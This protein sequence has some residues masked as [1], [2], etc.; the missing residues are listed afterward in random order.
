VKKHALACIFIV[1][2]LVSL[3]TLILP[4][5]AA[6]NADS[7]FSV[8]WITDTQYL[9]QNYLTYFNGLTQW[10]IQNKDAYNVKMVVHT[11]DLV[12]DEGNRAQWE[13]ANQSMTTLLADNI[14]YCWCAGNHDFNSSCWIGNQYASFNPQTLQNQPYWVASD[15][16]GLSTA[17]HFNVNGWDCL[18]LNLAFHANTSTLNWANNLLNEYPQSHAIVATHA[19]LDDKG[20]HDT[21][22]TNLKNTVMETHPN[23]FL[24][25]N[26]H[27]HPAS[28]KTLKVGDRYELFFNRQD[29]DGE[30]GADSARILT[31]DT[32][33]GTINVQTY[34]V[35]DSQFLT[36]ANNNFTLDSS[37]RNDMAGQNVPEFPVA[38]VLVLALSFSSFALVLL[39]RRGKLQIY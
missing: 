35:Y 24:T 5:K 14:P 3:S 39:V 18:I 17:V 28:S 1:V 6:P 23:V 32:A 22:A 34:I 9:T 30:M 4:S 11:G 29:V 27:Y 20:K 12:E 31:F 25:L 8:I 15:S 10:I 21:W 26:G 38:A 33:K 36:D 2:L 19:Y 13:I 16:S 37:F 7:T